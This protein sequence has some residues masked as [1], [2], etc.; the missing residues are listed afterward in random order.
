MEITKAQL[1]DELAKLELDWGDEEDLVALVDSLLLVHSPLMAWSWLC[2][3][4]NEL[5]GVPIVL[6][7]TGR[8]RDVCAAA[9]RIPVPT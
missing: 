3:Y 5:G 2:W 8:V 9:R 6:I 7:K 1:V 4:H